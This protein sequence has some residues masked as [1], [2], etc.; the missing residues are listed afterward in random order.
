MHVRHAGR[1]RV[2]AQSRGGSTQASGTNKQHVLML[3]QVYPLCKLQDAGLGE[4][5]DYREV[6]VLHPLLI[7]RLGLFE[8]AA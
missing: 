2:P 3:D 4:R 5:G 6:E 7:G 1:W 8:I